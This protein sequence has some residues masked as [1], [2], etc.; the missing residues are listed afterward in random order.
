MDRGGGYF[1]SKGVKSRQGIYLCILQLPFHV[2]T[3]NPVKKANTHADAR[4]LV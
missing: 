3:K 1:V 4:G 2:E